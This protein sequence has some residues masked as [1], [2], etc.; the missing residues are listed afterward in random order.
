M[1][2]SLRPALSSPLAWHRSKLMPWNAKSFRKYNKGLS[3]SQAGKA[4]KQANAVLRETG[5]E[6]LAIAVANK[7]AKKSRAEKRY[8]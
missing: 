4:A 5:D 3:G 2:S 8:K 7:H 6:G 1:P